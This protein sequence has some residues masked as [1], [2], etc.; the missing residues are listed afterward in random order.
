MKIRKNNMI[1]NSWNIARVSAVRLS[2]VLSETWL[3]GTGTEHKSKQNAWRGKKKPTRTRIGDV[4]SENK[5]A[6]VLN[7][8]KQLSGNWCLWQSTQEWG[9]DASIGTLIPQLW[10]YRD[11][12]CRQPAAALRCRRAGCAIGGSHARLHV[13]Y[14]IGTSQGCG[15]PS[16]T[17]PWRP[18]LLLQS[19]R[20]HP[21][22]IFLLNKRWVLKWSWF[23]WM[24]SFAL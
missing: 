23:V 12:H 24:K 6:L 21:P 5:I 9:F 14:N 8:E 18:T 19:L 11:V 4:E 15:L 20:T 2:L 17:T 13:S 16:D 3:I 7:V 1:N 10:H 22:W